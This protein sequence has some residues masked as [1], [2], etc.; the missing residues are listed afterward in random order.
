MTLLASHYYIWY[1]VRGD[2]AQAR[3]AVNTLMQ[4]VALRTGVIGRLLMRHD[5]PALW[6]EVY[7]SVADAQA[8]D[9]VLL[10][11]TSRSGIVN[12][13]DGGRHVERFINAL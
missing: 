6:M 9:L 5:D 4:E 11:A 2:G 10:E 3:S 7:E 8:F 1:R 12:F 13:A